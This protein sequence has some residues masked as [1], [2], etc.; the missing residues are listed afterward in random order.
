MSKIL[1]VLGVLVVIVLLGIA[2]SFLMRSSNNV[3]TNSTVSSSTD[4]ASTSTDKTVTTTTAKPKTVSSQTSTS[5]VYVDIT[6]FA[7]SPKA[8]TIKAGTT[9]TWTNRDSVIHTITADNGGPASPNIGKGQTYSFKYTKAG[10][11]GYH[12]SIHKTMT[13]TII[14]Q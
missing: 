4:V 7:F 8:L 9:V 10:I 13:G 5:R 14:V 2:F 12:C 1:K 6:N 11:Y 3:Y